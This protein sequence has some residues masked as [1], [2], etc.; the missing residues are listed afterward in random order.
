MFHYIIFI[1]I[2]LFVYLLTIFYLN[3]I[4]LINNNKLIRYLKYIVFGV[5]YIGFIYISIFLW[6]LSIYEYVCI[7]HS[8]EYV[9]II[10]TN[11][12]YLIKNLYL[13][14]VNIGLA[15]LIGNVASMGTHILHDIEISFF[16]KV[17]WVLAAVLTSSI[18]FIM[19]I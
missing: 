2:I 6:D 17:G 18:I 1:L 4:K 14:K 12:N 3:D 13:P 15:I 11:N 19:V 8:N 16:T 9:Y 10:E 7:L 5:F